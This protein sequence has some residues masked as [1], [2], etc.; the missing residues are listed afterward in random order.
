MSAR[1]RRPKRPHRT[2]PGS[3]PA[4]FPVPTADALGQPGQ[5]GRPHVTQIMRYTVV[6]IYAP[7]GPRTCP[8]GSPGTYRLTF[9]LA[10]PGRA[11][12][13]DEIDFA[14]LIAAGDSLLQ[15]GP[16]VH[17]LEIELDDGSGTHPHATVHVNEHHRLRDIEFEV[18][19]D[20]FYHAANLGHDLIAPALSRWA[21]LHDVSITT[22]GFQI[23]ELATT[24]KQFWVNRML[25]AV[26]AFS[27]TSG[28]SHVNHGFCSR[29]TARASARQNH[30][31]KPCRYFAWWKACS[32]CAT[33]GVL[34]SRQ[35]DSN[36]STSRPNGSL[37]M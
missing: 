4:A 32:R 15:V 11:V 13:Q 31:G 34:S 27:D 6:P 21:Y 20:S 7:G 2:P 37:Q 22:S 1:S 33:R 3:R 30:S 14:K 12:V 23:I 29:R 25:G 18:E 17:T 19:A 16:N 8:N 28:A 10:I 24:S 36:H 35:R 9:I 5:S 26:K